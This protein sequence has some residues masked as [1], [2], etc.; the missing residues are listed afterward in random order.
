MKTLLPLC[1][2]WLVPC[3]LSAQEAA[4]AALP[5]IGNYGQETADGYV[6]VAPEDFRW[7]EG[8]VLETTTRM[9]N[10][11]SGVAGQP[12][13]MEQELESVQTVNLIDA[14]HLSIELAST[15]KR[16]E[17]VTPDGGRQALPAPAIPAMTFRF[18]RADGGEWELKTDEGEEAALLANAVAGMA[19]A[20]TEGAQGDSGRAFIGEAPRRVGDSWELDATALQQL[21]GQFG[22][23]AATAG[24]KLNMDGLSGTVK[25]DRIEER[26]GESCAVL[27][28]E[29]EG[30][31]KM[32]LG[33]VAAQAGA[34]GGM[35]MELDITTTTW[36]SLERPLAVV[37][38]S[39][40]TVG[41][42]VMGMNVDSAVESV[43][44]S[45]V[46]LP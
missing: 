18:E 24:M 19:P 23:G 13:K 1:S 5:G 46:T 31:M 25:F 39:S 30:T 29:M 35:E 33:E 11:T 28:I 44:T 7:P 14:N 15:I 12:G 2:L 34:A 41:M 6:L 45:K 26:E 43:T 27:L 40:G 38:E 36:R 20:M 3:L 42:E 22:G 16:M 8:A 37:Q 32:D 4:T 10:T 21:A 9:T 17:M